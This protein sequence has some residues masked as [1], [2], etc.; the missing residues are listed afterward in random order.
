MW[1]INK[2]VTNRDKIMYFVAYCSPSEK[3]FDDTV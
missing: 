1:K 3:G 2:K